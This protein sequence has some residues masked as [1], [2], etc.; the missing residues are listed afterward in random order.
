MVIA[1]IHD[2]YADLM[3]AAQFVGVH[4]VSMRR[5][6]KQGKV[7]AFLWQGKYLIERS[8]L[9]QFKA[10]YEARPSKNNFRRLI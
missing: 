3:E 8:T 10:N 6:I 2:Q 9:N 5:L 1:E 7:P 4:P